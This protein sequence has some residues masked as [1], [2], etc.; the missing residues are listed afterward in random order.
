VIAFVDA[1]AAAIVAGH[2]PTSALAEAGSRAADDALRRFAAAA[3]VGADI[4]SALVDLAVV[5]GSDGLAAVAACWAIGEQTGAALGRSLQQVATGL[6]A[7]DAAR[8]EVRS[9]LAPA[10]ATARILAALPA[11]GLLL[12]ASLGGQP[13][14]WLLGTAAGCGCLLLGVVLSAVG[15]VWVDRM[16]RAAGPAGGP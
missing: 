6:R 15:M 10:R 14:R 11:F 16:A 8:R 3:L 13:V 2:P 1:A 7:D 4:G 5:E 9:V 12:G